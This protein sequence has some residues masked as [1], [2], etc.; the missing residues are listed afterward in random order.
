VVKEV[1]DMLVFFMG[2]H[3]EYHNQTLESLLVEVAVVLLLLV[4]LVVPLA[5]EVVDLAAA[6]AE[7]HLI[8]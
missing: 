6:M 8:V 2:Q 7:T 1:V 5:A 4:D 3:Q